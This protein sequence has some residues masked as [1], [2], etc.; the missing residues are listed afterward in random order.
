LCPVDPERMDAPRRAAPTPGLMR[1]PAD[2]HHGTL[3]AAATHRP[4]IVHGEEA[5]GSVAMAA[6]VHLAAMG[7]ASGTV[8]AATMPVDFH[9][10]A[11]TAITVTRRHVNHAPRG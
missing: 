1:M 7:M 8:V 4:S 9:V 5:L 3:D 2:S 10:H 6:A 11:G